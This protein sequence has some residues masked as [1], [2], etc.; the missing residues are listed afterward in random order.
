[1]LCP[2]V[3]RFTFSESRSQWDAELTERRER[4]QHTQ[5]GREERRKKNNK[6]IKRGSNRQTQLSLLLSPL[7]TPIRLPSRVF[8]CP[9]FTPHNRCT[10]QTRPTKTPPNPAPTQTHNH[11]TTTHRTRTRTPTT[12]I[13]TVIFHCPSSC[14]CMSV[15]PVLVR[16]RGWLVGWLVLLLSLATLTTLNVNADILRP[17]S[18]RMNN[19]YA[20]LEL[21][22]LSKIDGTMLQ[23]EHTRETSTS[24]GTG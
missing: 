18:G 22:A 10:N 9:S 1:M 8:P 4:E 11:Q 2:C 15:L 20:K 14:S 23:Y 24:V 5:N 17:P 7:H 13:R 21:L 16:P 3:F 12:Y 6:K 19:V